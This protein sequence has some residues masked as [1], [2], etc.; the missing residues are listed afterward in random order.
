MSPP[1]TP[2]WSPAIIGQW[3]GPGSRLSLPDII[4]PINLDNA[5]NKTL[6]IHIVS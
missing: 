5:H 6:G 1:V 3:W 2:V 4:N